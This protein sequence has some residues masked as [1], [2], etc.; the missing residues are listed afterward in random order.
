[1]TIGPRF[2]HASEAEL[3]RIFDYY[4]VRWEYEPRS[5]AILWNLDGQVVESFAPDFYLPELDLFVE[6]TTLKQGLVR[7]KNR[8]LRRLKELYP[9][10]RIRLFYAKDF[11]ALMLKYG[12]IDVAA[13]FI[14]LEGQTN[15]GARV[16]RHDASVPAMA[17][18]GP[19]ALA[20]EAS[21]RFDGPLDAVAAIAP[22]AGPP[23]EPPSTTAGDREP[24]AAPAVRQRRSRRRDARTRRPGRVG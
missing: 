18:T 22:A 14:G 15:V 8:K 10:L 19:V 23:T 4:Q 5:F 6:L 9:W 1:M 13:S 17:A 21:E 24:G 7:K 16:R 3:A 20:T 2:A 11:K 12:R